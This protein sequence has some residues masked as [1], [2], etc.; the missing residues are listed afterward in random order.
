MKSVFKKIVLGILSAVMAFACVSCSSLFIPKDV[1][2]VYGNIDE[3]GFGYTYVFEGDTVKYSL[4]NN[5]VEEVKM[6]GTYEIKGGKIKLISDEYFD[7]CVSEDGKYVASKDISI[8]TDENGN[9]QLK[10]GINSFGKMEEEDLPIN[11]ENPENPEE[12]P[13]N[14][15]NPE[16]DPDP[17]NPNNSN[18]NT[19]ATVT[20][21][22]FKTALI[23]ASKTENANF[24]ASYS[25]NEEHKEGSRTERIEYYMQIK[26]KG[27]DRYL[28]FKISSRD[29][30]GGNTHSDVQTV[31]LWSVGGTTYIKT[32]YE[33]RVNN[34]TVPKQTNTAKAS[35]QTF[36]AVCENLGF[37]TAAVLDSPS[38]LNGLL[39]DTG[40]LL[41]NKNGTTEYTLDCTGKSDALNAIYRMSK[42]FA[43]KILSDKF[44]DAEADYSVS[45]SSGLSVTYT[46]SFA[47][48]SRNSS[49]NG[50]VNF[51]S[52]NP[53]ITV[54]SDVSLAEDVD[55][56]YKSWY[57]SLDLPHR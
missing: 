9:E 14:P 3:K 53:T 29:S 8:E 37:P 31:E 26:A 7:G 16:E 17:N 2:G 33:Q 18:E 50:A 57:S 55:A 51:K 56:G 39:T 10:I 47:E 1:T 35:G 43:V 23:N 15:E 48:P 22:D 20:M 21:S 12:N 42:A 4:W 49:V 11:P 45:S 44:D 38:T 19:T 13:E 54:P 30:D 52:S 5:G 6:Q 24:E 28:K 41:E 25:L 36:N 27:T 40:A 34:T 32:E 46:A